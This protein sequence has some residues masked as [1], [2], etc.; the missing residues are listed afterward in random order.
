MNLCG[1]PELGYDTP[2]N[3]HT[4]ELIAAFA[5][6]FVMA[7][8][9]ILFSNLPTKKY[10]VA[11]IISFLILAVL[12]FIAATF[13]KDEVCSF[14]PG[15]AAWHCRVEQMTPAAVTFCGIAYAIPFIGGFILDSLFIRL[16]TRRQW[17]TYILIIAA[18][19]A[20]AYFYAFILNLI[21]YICFI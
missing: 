14:L 17:F 20:V 6:F 15:G 7:C 9:L 16:T 3:F 19:I 1:W 13:F 10:I 5:Y 8:S 2:S 11:N 21:T 18:T 4:F 12:I